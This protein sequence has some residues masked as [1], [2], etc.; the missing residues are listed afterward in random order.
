MDSSELVAAQYWL[1]VWDWV[2]D[3]AFLIVVIAL[4]IEFMAA[5]WAKPHREALDHAR[6]LE[7]AELRK[8]ASEAELA[9]A[10]IKLPRLLAGKPLAQ[11]SEKMKPFAG[12]KFD[13]AITPGSIEPENFSVSVERALVAVGWVELDWT[14]TEF[15]FLLDRSTMKM[16]KAGSIPTASAIVALAHPNDPPEVWSAAQALARALD[17]AGF[18]AGA[19][20]TMTTKS[21]NAATVHLIVGEKPL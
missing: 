5:R 12:T 17:E 9:L 19:G 2:G 20:N 7:V 16:P 15:G 3:K 10:K 1:S 18:A 4:A 11:F 8:D 6:E 13:V 21:T 14:Q